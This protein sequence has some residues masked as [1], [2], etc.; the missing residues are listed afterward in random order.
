MAQLIDWSFS[1]TSILID[2]VRRTLADIV[3]LPLM[4]SEKSDTQELFSY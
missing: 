3:L 2:S 1:D 4:I